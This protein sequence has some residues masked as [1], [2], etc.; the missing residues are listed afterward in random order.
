MNE[1]QMRLSLS[2]LVFAYQYA[3]A[4]KKE[5]VNKHLELGKQLLAKGQFADALQQYHSAVEL[6]PTDYQ[7][8]YR[9]A[10]VY[11]AMG[12]V[13]AALPDLDKVVELKPDF[14]AV[15]SV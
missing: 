5:E 7:T 2:V 6:D 3:V 10:T 12:R 1:K 15:P 11:L 14:I 13:K 4:V 9:R 8:Y